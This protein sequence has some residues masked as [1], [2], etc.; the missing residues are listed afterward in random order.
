MNDEV[1]LI[2]IRDE[3][4]ILSYNIKNLSSLLNDKLECDKTILWKD[5]NTNIQLQVQDT[6]SIINSIISID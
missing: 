4:E 5:S 6:K 2:S 3:L 1:K